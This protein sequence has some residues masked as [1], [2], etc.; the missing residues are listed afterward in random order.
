MDFL[1]QAWASLDKLAGDPTPQARK[2][3]LERLAWLS[4]LLDARFSVP[5]KLPIIGSFKFGV[6]PLLDLIPY[7]GATFGALIS[8]YML[9]EL[10]WGVWWKGYLTRPLDSAR[11]DLALKFNIPKFAMFR[12]FMLPGL[13]LGLSWVPV[14][15]NDGYPRSSPNAISLT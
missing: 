8:G 9:C 11:T 4:V 12:L 3:N 7:G 10:T 13:S 5:F 14:G 15:N 2:A 1:K 6:M